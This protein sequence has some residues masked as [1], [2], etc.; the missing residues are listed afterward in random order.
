M[1]DLVEPVGTRLL[2]LGGGSGVTTVVYGNG[3]RELVVLEPDE[4][5]VARGR[6][7]HAPVT[8]VPGVA[9]AIPFGAGAFDR[10]VS[11]MAFHHFSDGAKAVQEAARV[12]RPGGRLVVYD[13]ERGSTPARLMEFWEVRVLRHEMRLRT[14]A[15]LEA[16]VRASGFSDVRREPHGSGAFVT[17]T[18]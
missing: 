7:A 9:E 8:F 17:G 13:V 10:V 3:A 15:E 14:G 18:R 2:D 12:L 1:R 5:K 16:L 11:L 4:H 6:S